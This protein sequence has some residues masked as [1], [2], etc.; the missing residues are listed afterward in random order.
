M[1][2]EQTM[3]SG[4]LG[5]LALAEAATARGDWAE[6]ASAW[7][8][9]TAA[10]PVEGRFWN[11]LGQARF[12]TADYAGAI[13]AFEQALALGHGDPA[14]TARS[15]ARCHVRRGDHEAALALIERALSLGLRSLQAVRGSEDFTQLR[16]LPRFRELTGLIDRDPMT[17][18]EGWRFDLRLLARETRRLAYAPWRHVS[19]T[20]FDAEVARI[21][22]AIP[23]L[24]DLQVIVEFS[25]LLALLGDG[26]AGVYPPPDDPENRRALPL[27]FFRFEDGIFIIAARPEQ[28]DLLGAELLAI[29]DYAVADAVIAVTPLICRDN[30]HWLKYAVP[31]R[32][33]ETPVL[34]ALGLIPDRDRALL[35]IRTLDDETRTIEIGTETAYPRALLQRHFYRPADWLFLP[36]VLP[37]PVPHALRNMRLAYWFEV[38]PGERL[39]YAQINGVQNHPS[40]SLEAFSH[41]MIDAAEGPAIDRLVLDLRWNSGGNTFLEMPLIHRLIGSRTL[42]RR[43][44]LYVII[45]RGTFSAAQNL[46]TLLERHT[47]AIFVGEPTGSS[48]T[49]VGETIDFQLPYSGAWANVSDL[50]WQSGWPMDERTWIAPL[51]YTPPTFADF[52]ENRDPAMEAILA[53]RE[54]MPGAQVVRWD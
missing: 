40:E 48:P 29:G 22:A 36:E 4:F 35:T 24:T 37:G 52:R 9:V 28:A 27:Q 46:A 54:E 8:Q 31:H 47:E 41:R 33:R 23:D 3:M 16:P 7:E 11:R 39:L 17:R 20:E 34:H 44:R 19:E 38:L 6:A 45:G 14:E 43:G 15:I 42:N 1:T 21:D 26:H 51:L 53:V 10:N 2:Q 18:D 5:T 25:R 12:Q 50:L 30:E 32:L 49:F 13:P